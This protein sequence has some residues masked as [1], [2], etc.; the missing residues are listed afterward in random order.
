MI[1]GEFTYRRGSYLI[2][3][4]DRPVCTIE[5]FDA[6]ALKHWITSEYVTDEEI[7]VYEHWTDKQV[8]FI[9]LDK[10]IRL[11]HLVID[12]VKYGIRYSH[13]V[14][15]VSENQVSAEII[16]ANPALRMDKA[17]STLA[18]VMV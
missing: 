1:V 7:P 14:G 9:Y 4:A 8:G 6:A 3:I 16:G 11:L 12:G 2:K 18:G 13:F 15:V 5:R 17:Q 10:E